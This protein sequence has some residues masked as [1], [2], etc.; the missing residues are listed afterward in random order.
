ML[1]EHEELG[2][3]FQYT[4]G[5]FRD[6]T[7][8]ASSDA[9][10]WRDIAIYNSEAIVKWLKNYGLA[11]EELAGLVESKDADALYTLFSEAKKARDKHYS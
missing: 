3:V 9:V 4:A 6:F 1:N 2:D 5:G 10:M 7:R 8:I 11:I